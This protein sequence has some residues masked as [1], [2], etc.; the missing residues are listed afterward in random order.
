MF[1]ACDALCWKFTR[2]CD[3]WH[4]G[5]CTKKIS[6]IVQQRNFWLFLNG[7]LCCREK[8]FL[9]KFLI[10][11]V[12]VH[13]DVWCV[14]KPIFVQFITDHDTLFEHPVVR[15]LWQSGVSCSLFE[16]R[17]TGPCVHNVKIQ[18]LRFKIQD[19]SFKLQIWLVKAHAL[20]FKNQN[21][22][23][24]TMILSRST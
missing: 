12:G 10:A 20:K 23:V 22:A 16:F 8:I 1:S 19:S 17:L 14:M 4:D 2:N 21:L 3:A 7:K 9:Y 15:V 13:Q 24:I 5:K 6:K 18:N 11:L